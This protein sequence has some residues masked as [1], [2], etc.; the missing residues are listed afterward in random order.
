MI[1]NLEM[2]RWKHNHE[3]V[4]ITDLI[5]E[6]EYSKNPNVSIITDEEISH[7]WHMYRDRMYYGTKN[8]CILDS[9]TL[10]KYIFGKFPD[11]ESLENLI[12]EYKRK[13]KKKENQVG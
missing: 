6:I 3:P 12:N 7:I 13:K 4:C 9:K 11:G 1:D 8:E 10:E 5:P 2:F